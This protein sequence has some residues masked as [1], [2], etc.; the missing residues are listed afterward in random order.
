MNDNSFIVEPVKAREIAGVLYREYKKGEG[1]FENSGRLSH[2][3]P[4]GMIEGSKV[5]SLYLT[6]IFVLD[7]STRSEELWSQARQFYQE[8][9]WFFD[10]EQILTRSDEG[11]SKALTILGISDTSTSVKRWKT[12]SK[13]LLEDYSGDPR[14]IADKTRDPIVVRKRIGEILGTKDN[15]RIRRYQQLMTTSRL[16]KVTK[17]KSHGVFADEYI[18]VFTLCTGVLR[19]EGKLFEGSLDADPILSLTRKAWNEVAMGIPARELE[20]AISLVSRSLCPER[21]CIICPI[22]QKCEKRFGLEISGKKI[23]LRATSVGVAN[24][25]RFC[26]HCGRELMRNSRFCDG[27]GIDL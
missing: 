14:R 19:F 2:E 24:Q 13:I 3:L 6:Y 18:A 1:P 11:L 22:Y 16:L 27:C 10:T 5:H 17:P 15:G 25:M 20:D 9:P 7:Q 26:S 8:T 12:I 23:R 21:R 4:Q